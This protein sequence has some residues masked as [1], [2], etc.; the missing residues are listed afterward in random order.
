MMGMLTP[1]A[2][3]QAHASCLPFFH[4]NSESYMHGGVYLLDDSMGGFNNSEKMLDKNGVSFSPDNASQR[5]CV[6]SFF[7]Q[8]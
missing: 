5:D 2:P 1:T 3:V 4:D 8:K 7:I 6:A